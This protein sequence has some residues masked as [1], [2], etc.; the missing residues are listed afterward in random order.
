[1]L[2][3]TC[4]HRKPNRLPEEERQK[5]VQKLLTARR[6]YVVLEIMRLCKNGT[7]ADLD[8]FLRENPEVNLALSRR[9]RYHSY[10]PLSLATSTWSSSVIGSLN[11]TCSPDQAQKQR[12]L[13]RG[14]HILT[15]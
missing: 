11:S 15:N 10:S 13:C 12:M 5:R 2:L 9:E 6:N 8:R 7:V 3:H 4:L 14:L 1:V